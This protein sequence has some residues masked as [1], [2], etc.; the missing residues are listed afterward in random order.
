MNQL[1]EW[2]QGWFSI[3]IMGILGAS[4]LYFTISLVSNKKWRYAPDILTVIIG[5]FIIVCVAPF[6][7]G[8][9]TFTVISITTCGI[10]TSLIF[11][12]IKGKKGNLTPFGQKN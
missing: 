10:A 7:S 4:I 6:M 11:T 12:F 3:V 5:I 1:N 2:T 9:G 8:W